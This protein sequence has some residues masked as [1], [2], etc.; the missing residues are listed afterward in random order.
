MSAILLPFSDSLNAVWAG[1]EAHVRRTHEAGLTPAVNMDTGY[2][3]LLDA[4]SRA[5]ALAIA[6]EVTDGA[7]VAGAFV[8]DEPG[9]AVFGIVQGFDFAGIEYALRPLRRGH[10]FEIGDQPRHIGKEFIQWAERGDIQGHGQMT[11]PAPPFGL[12]GAS[13]AVQE[14]TA[15]QHA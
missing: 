9:A 1:F 5:R 2:V 8:P 15:R 11:R 3:Q 10:R 13:N 4:P 7:F 6:A 14:P 12:V